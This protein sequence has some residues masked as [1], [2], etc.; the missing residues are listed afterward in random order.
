M[1]G[2]T[3]NGEAQS[4]VQCLRQFATLSEMS[5]GGRNSGF[6]LHPSKLDWLEKGGLLIENTNR[7]NYKNRKKLVRTLVRERYR[8]RP[9]R[10]QTAFS[11]PLRRERPLPHKSGCSPPPRGGA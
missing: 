3:K 5:H 4:C 9:D 6:G 1:A 2:A 10:P 11:K 8:E 7:R